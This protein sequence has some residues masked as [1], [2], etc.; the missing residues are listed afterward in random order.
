MRLNSNFSVVR[1][2][3]MGFA[4]FCCLLKTQFSSSSIFVC[5]LVASCCTYRNI[6]YILYNI[7]YGQKSIRWLPSAQEDYI[8]SVRGNAQAHSTSY[9]HTI[10][11]NIVVI[12]RCH[13]LLH[14]YSTLLVLFIYLVSS[15][16]CLFCGMF[17]IDD[18]VLLEHCDS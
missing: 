15:I 11:Y 14:L 18:N 7:L 6:A 4:T 10:L 5:H 9:F 2:I 17:V 16:S 12:F 3:Y 1:G 13:V 8:N